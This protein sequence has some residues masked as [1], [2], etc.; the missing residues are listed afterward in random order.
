M[1]HF[2]IELTDG[3]I[4]HVRI[5]SEKTDASG[6]VRIQRIAFRV[7]GCTGDAWIIHPTRGT[8]RKHRR[9]LGSRLY[10]LRMQTMRARY[11]AYGY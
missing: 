5:K 2:E 11:G 1:P 6:P 10:R 3:N 9:K 4:C 8:V 7:A